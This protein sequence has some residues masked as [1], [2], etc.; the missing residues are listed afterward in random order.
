MKHC[1]TCQ[2]KYADD[3]QSYCMEDGTPLVTEA[4]PSSSSPSVYNMQP[5]IAASS[6]PG[7]SELAPTEAYRPDAANA[8]WSA[9]AYQPPISTPPPAPVARKRNALPWIIGGTAILLVGFLVIVIIV[10]IILASNASDENSNVANSSVNISRN[11][12]TNPNINTNTS[13]RNSNTNALDIGGVSANKSANQNAARSDAGG[14]VAP[15]DTDAVMMQLTTLEDVWTQ[16][17]VK[18]DK[19]TLRNILADEYVGKEMDGTLKSK[20]QYLATLMPSSTIKTW[21]FSDLK[22]NL[23]GNKAVLSGFITVRGDNLNETYKFTDAFVWR[24]GD[25]RATGSEAVLVK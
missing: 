21:R 8:A 16:A 4:S 22:L 23:N 17:N 11:S 6:S 3:T 20:T 1:P 5:T 10:A 18:G 15:R 2:R 12:N 25:W 24:D 7:R 19:E 13:S 14:N 9:P